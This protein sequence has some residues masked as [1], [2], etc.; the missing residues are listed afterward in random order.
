MCDWCVA[1]AEQMQATI[2]LLRDL[3][4]AG[5]P[6]PTDAVLSALR[7]KKASG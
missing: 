1:Y 6:E 2:D 5:S 4:E 3:R 7:G